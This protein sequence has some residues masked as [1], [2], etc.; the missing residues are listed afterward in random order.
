MSRQLDPNRT[1]IFNEEI[2]VGAEAYFGLPNTDP[3]VVANRIPI[4][5]D[6]EL[7]V[8]ISQPQQTNS[9]GVLPPIYVNVVEYSFAVDTSP[10]ESSQQIVYEPELEGLNSGGVVTS[11]IDMN[12][13]K[14][15][16]VGEATANNQYATLGQSNKAYAQV[17]DS[18]AASTPNAIVAILPIAP[19]ALVDGQQVVVNLKHAANDNSVVTLTL[20]NFAPK[21][22]YIENNALLPLRSTVGQDY[23]A[24]F[25]YDESLDKFFFA[26]PRDS[27]TRKYV[28][29]ANDTFV[30][31]PGVTRLDFEVVGAGGGGG[32][33]SAITG[34][35]GSTFAIGAGGGPGAI[36]QATTETIAASYDVTVGTGGSGGATGNN[37]GLDGGDS[38]VT[39]GAAFTLTAEG[40]TGGSG[41]APESGGSIGLPGDGT[42]SDTI[43]IGSSGS[44]AN[45]GTN[46]FNKAEAALLNTDGENAISLAAGGNGGL[47]LDA[48]GAQPA[49]SGG[50]GYEGRVIITEYI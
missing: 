26:N 42:G 36:V 47:N 7:T 35:A 2:A 43:L 30:P 48:G 10:A 23:H 49:R 28:F 50:D 5:S 9:E 14:H 31:T 12:G 27:R 18:D 32:G 41:G 29:T 40:G 1:Y 38:I 22:C 46:I 25:I 19:D 4:F 21:Q 44:S 15:V 37:A 34:G 8:P 24:H 3:R 33:A 45:G 6:K 13:F 39:D 11:D 17:V 20:N 16:N